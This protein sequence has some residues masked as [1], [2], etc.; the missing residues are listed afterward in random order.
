MAVSARALR[1]GRAI[2]ELGLDSTKVEK[3]LKDLQA[4]V[5]SIGGTLARFGSFGIIGGGLGGLRNL[6]V[7]SAATAALAFPV[8]MA[9]NLELTAAQLAVFV[10]GIDVANKML[11][12][13]QAFSADSM[14]PFE[15]L[16]RTAALLVR[17][18]QSA[19]QAT[20]NTEALA[21]L[22]A[23]DSDEFEKL[24][25]AFAQVGSAGRLQGE[26]MRQFKN[27]AFNPLREIAE[28]TGET[29]D[30]VK[31]RM[32][33]GGVSFDEVSSALQAAVGP[34]GRFNGLLKSISNTM[35]GQMSKAWSQF[36]LILLPLGQQVLAPITK[37]FKAINGIMPILGAFIARNA[38]IAKVVL[39]VLITVAAA[40]V[41]FT[42]LGLGIQLAAVAAA[43]FATLLSLIASVLAAILS[44]VG[45]LVAGLAALTYWF[46]TS[47]ESGRNMANDLMAYFGALVQV[48]KDTFSGI[49]DALMAGDIQLAADI[50]WAGLKLAWLKGTDGMRSVWNSFKD[51]FMRTTLDMVF[52]A[53]AMWEKFSTGV[54]SVWASMVTESKTVGENIGHWLTRSSDPDLARDQDAAHNQALAR[55][56]SEGA[57]DLNRLQGEKQQAL[58]DIEA[59]RKTAEDAQNKAATDATDKAKKD[60]KD[61]Q[62]ALD[63]LRKKA[64][65]KAANLPDGKK[66]F[67]ASEFA[68][69]LGAGLDKAKKSSQPLPAIFDTRLA[70]EI[71]GG[72]RNNVQQQQLK[73]QQKIEKNTRRK[74]GTWELVV[75]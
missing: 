10:G 9:G 8:K 31:K 59:A 32:E 67:G 45:L 74:S 26:E 73:I 37:F 36:K 71:Y 63:R 65:D 60:L 68:S 46:F 53:Q 51:V 72:N 28:R 29:M 6:F 47:T 49:A 75:V 5:K 56:K 13:L 21:V 70:A 52:G 33:A 55:I 4:R 34:A 30:E 2:I 7:G 24:A 44:P 14:M 11:A 57:A 1:A 16:S 58:D 43:G 27:T 62:D 12:E 54:K 42:T 17:Y 38:G 35:L 19:D 22:A 40:A 15:G 50:L 48:A 25:L 23:G 61:A 41:V 69:G 39:A 3:G 20:K 66:W 64:A 18:G